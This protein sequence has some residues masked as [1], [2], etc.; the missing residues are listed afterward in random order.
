VAAGSGGHILPA[1]QLGTTWL[2]KNQNGK[3]MVFSSKKKLDE[4]ILRSCSEITHTI[5][6]NI[7]NYAQLGILRYPV[8]CVQLMIAFL[9]SL[10]GLIR[11]SPSHVISTGSIHTIP[12]VLAAK[13]IRIPVHLYE[14]NAIPGKAVTFLAPFATSINGVFNESKK[15][16]GNNQKKFN[17]VPYPLKYEKP[18]EMRTKE[19]LIQILNATRQESAPLFTVER[20]TLLLLGGSQGSQQL[21]EWLQNFVLRHTSIHKEI[22]IIHQTGI[23]TFNVNEFYKNLDIPALVFDFTNDLTSSYQLADLII[24]RAGAGTLFEVTYFKKRSI[25]VPLYTS[26]T[27]HQYDNALEM[28]R[29]F[30]ELCTIVPEKDLK[31]NFTHLDK[32]VLEKVGL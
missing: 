19:S 24:C 3:I 17:H 29:S 28:N 13:L 21:N 22:Q 4:K 15:Y 9:K 10:Y 31:K 18:P 27:S 26:T 12:V 25:I 6:L 30:P 14:L 7:N 8:Q 1:L 11:F 2:K 20:K 16:F 5:S 23:S 32:M